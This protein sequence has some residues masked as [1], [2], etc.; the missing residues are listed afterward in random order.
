M[1]P[2][3]VKDFCQEYGLAGVSMEQGGSL[4]LSIEDIGD[5]QLVH[6]HSKL[7]TGLTRPIGNTYLMDGRK[8]L[9]FCHFKESHLRPLHAQINDDNILGLS[10]HFDESE[11][12]ATLL[13]QALNSLTDIM[14]NIF[15]TF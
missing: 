7:I 2:D 15:Q 8:I 10:Y 11:V 3:I 1:I 12:T 9:S 5:F 4:R 14:D 6:T 13:S